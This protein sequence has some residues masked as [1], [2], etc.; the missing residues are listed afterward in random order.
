MRLFLLGATGRTGAQLVD[1][2]VQ[3]GHEVTAFVRS[4][5]KL[6]RRTGLEVVK[7][8]VRDERALGRAMVGHDAVLSALGPAPRQAMTGTTLL[9]DAAHATVVAMR[10][11]GVGRIALVSS[12]LLFPAGG[13]AVRI[14]RRIIGPHVR[15]LRG[16][17]AIVQDDGASWTL[18]RP[19]RLVQSPDAS[20][21]AAVDDLPGG[22][23]LRAWL[24]WRAV[25]A[26]LLDCVGSDLHPC[27]VVGI[28][29]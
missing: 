6:P 13:A 3:R 14:A 29:H 22:L 21:R 27:R 16:M 20:Y 4:P 8:D 9:R 17:E 1:L 2:A 25:A 11:A 24:S 12:A 23:S 26:F 5:G 28:A 10:S 18:A 7:G 19:P 15:D